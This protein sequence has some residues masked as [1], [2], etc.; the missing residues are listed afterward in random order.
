MSETPMPDRRLSTTQS[1]RIGGHRIH[2]TVGFYDEACTQVGEIFLSIART[3]GQE[4][5]L[6]DEIARSASKRLQR[7]EPLAELAESWLGTK[8]LPYGIVEGDAR[9]KLCSGPLDWAGRHLL[10]FYAGREDLAHAPAPIE[11]TT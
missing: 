9:I 4:R 5:A 10:I 1:V 11:E 2:M 3:G 7:G 6:L 8:L